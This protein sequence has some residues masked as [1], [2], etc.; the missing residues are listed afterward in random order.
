MITVLP[1]LAQPPTPSST[2]TPLSAHDL[3]LLD[4][5]FNIGELP[6]ESSKKKSPSLQPIT[7]KDLDKVSIRNGGELLNAPKVNLEKLFK[8]LNLS[9]GQFSLVVDCINN[10]KYRES[11]CFV[12]Q[13][14]A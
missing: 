2:K 6:F 3:K 14:Q 5:V 10:L 9:E 8:K 4:S 7:A 1:M 13:G 12:S 11:F